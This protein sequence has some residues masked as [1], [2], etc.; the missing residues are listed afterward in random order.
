MPQVAANIR[1]FRRPEPYHGKGIRYQ[2]EVVLLRAAKTAK[3]DK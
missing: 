2:G 3:K 1:S